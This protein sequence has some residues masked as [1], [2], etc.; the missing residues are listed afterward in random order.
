MPG[1]YKA[2]GYLGNT[3][4][5][6][7]YVKDYQ[8]T[9]DL[10]TMESKD[11]RKYKVASREA[12]WFD[13]T[14]Y[15]HLDSKYHN[16][17]EK[18]VIPAARMHNSFHNELYADNKEYRDTEVIQQAKKYKNIHLG[19]G[20]YVNQS[21]RINGASTRKLWN[22]CFQFYSILTLIAMEKFRRVVEREGLSDKFQFIA[23]IYD[24][25]YFLVKRETDLLK[26]TAKTLESIMTE[27]FLEN[28]KIK[29]QADVEIGESWADLVAINDIEDL[30]EYL[31]GG[32]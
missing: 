26:W 13:V 22:S 15:K 29:L 4:N 14:N 25:V 20:A 7:I 19:M 31:K 9:T 16:F 1:L 3:F 11:G 2:V 8:Y 6:D 27:D 5:D 21:T 10:K 30:D 17:F 28:Q 24:S 18:A 12:A 23:S 32:N